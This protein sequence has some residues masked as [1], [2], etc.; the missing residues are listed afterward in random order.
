MSCYEWER[1]VFKIPT[2]EY[3]SFRKA[4][5]QSWNDRQDEIFDRAVQIFD[6]IK[7]AGKGRR[8]FNF[9][10]KR[11]ELLSECD[12]EDS[13]M[14]WLV[15][16]TDGKPKH[17]PKKKHLQQFPISRGA[18]L[19]LGEACIVFTD[20]TRTVIWNVY[21]GNHACEYAREHPMAKRFFNLLGGIQW[22]RKT[23]GSIVGNDEYNDDDRSEGGGANYTKETYGVKQA[24][25]Y[26]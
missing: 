20:K 4:M 25:P 13:S 3:A 5:I 11:N 15:R 19:E 16:L 10:G 21:E 14:G 2:K 17:K 1:G 23:G 24:T 7:E 26:L 12:S 18:C 6:E 8:N 9:E 22:A